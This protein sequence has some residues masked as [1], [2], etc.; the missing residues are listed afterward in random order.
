MQ[1]EKRKGGLGDKRG[2]ESNAWGKVIHHSMMI[3]YRI[4]GWF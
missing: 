4:N 2:W 1:K 3:G